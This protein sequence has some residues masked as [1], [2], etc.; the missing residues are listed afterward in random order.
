MST[1]WRANLQAKFEARKAAMGFTEL[2]PAK[3]T[4]RRVRP[5]LPQATYGAAPSVGTIIT[6]R[7]DGEP[8]GQPRVKAQLVR[9]KRPSA[10]PFIHIYTPDSAKPWKI[11]VRAAAW[12]HQPGCPIEGPVGVTID[13]LLPRPKYL[14]TPWH[15]Q[16]AAGELRACCKPDRDNLDKLIL[17]TLTE[18]RFWKDD[19]QVCD[20]PVRKWYHAIG[21]QPG[22]RVSIEVLSPNPTPPKRQRAV[23]LTP[24]LFT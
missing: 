7:V 15:E 23:E 16:N 6:F 4:P 18:L 17:D 21:E 8:L 11:A 10:K 20:G 22:V 12:R 24:L 13:V 3:P 1:S 9:P 19:A 5:A 14:S 2:P